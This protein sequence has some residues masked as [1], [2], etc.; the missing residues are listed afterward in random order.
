[1]SSVFK[2]F[3]KQIYGRAERAV[4]VIR[5]ITY[6]HSF[7]TNR[8]NFNVDPSNIFFLSLVYFSLD[9]VILVMCSKSFNNIFIYLIL[10]LL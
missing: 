8:L 1:M 9:T 7:A 2:S 4:T 10:S 5:F 6:M 3:V